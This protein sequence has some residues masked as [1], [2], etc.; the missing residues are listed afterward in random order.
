MVLAGVNV[1]SCNACQLQECSKYIKNCNILWILTEFLSTFQSS[2]NLHIYSSFIQSI[3]WHPRVAV[4]CDNTPSCALNVL[5]E[6]MVS[7]CRCARVLPWKFSIESINKRHSDRTWFWYKH[8][9]NWS[10]LLQKKRS[11][12]R[13]ERSQVLISLSE[14]SGTNMIVSFEIRC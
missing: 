11:I 7:Y 1:N 8:G 13:K 2:V 12:H 5:R 9:N 4:F 6:W 3:L 10:M 14:M